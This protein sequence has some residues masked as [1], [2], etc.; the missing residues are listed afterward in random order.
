MTTP[1]NAVIVY[2]G[3]VPSQIAAAPVGEKVVE[4]Y[5][6]NGNLF[7]TSQV[8]Q[9]ESGGGTLLGY[10]DVG[11]AENYRTYFSSLPNSVL[12]PQ[13]PSWPG[14]YQVEYWSS[15]WLSVS[16][17]YIKTMIT[18]GF[19]GCFLD[20][21]TNA[22]TSWAK[23]NAPGGDSEGAMI[24]LIQDVAS[25]AHSINPNFK[26]YAN[27]SGAEDMLSNPSLVKAVDGVFEESL[28][29]QSATQAQ[30]SADV[31][32][33]VALL[34]NVTAAGKPVIDVEY[35][36]N[37]S[38][39]ASVESKDKAYGFGYY[40]ANPDQALNGVDT[41]G[42]TSGATTPGAPTVA[43]T[44]TGGT[45]TSAA[46]TISGTVDVADAGTT[47]KVLEGTTQI[48]S[49]TVGSNGA[50]AAAVTLPT[51]GVNVIAASDSNTTGTGTSNAVTYTLHTVAPTVTITSAGG[52]VTSA[53]QTISGTVDVADASSTVKV[54]DGNAQ[55]GAATVGANGAWSAAVTLPNPGANTISAT[56][57][58][59]AGTG[60][61][62]AVTYT[63]NSASPA[64]PSVKIANSQITVTGGGGTVAMGVSVSAPASSTSTTV[65]IAGLPWYERIT[66]ASDGKTFRGSSITLTQ[67]EVNSGLTL[68]SR[69][70]GAGHPVATLSIT[71][72]DT[73]GGVNYVSPAQ[74]LTV[75]DPPPATSS[76]H[77]D[78]PA[79]AISSLVSGLERPSGFE[80]NQNTG[81]YDGLAC[82][83]SG[84]ATILTNARKTAAFGAG[85]NRNVAEAIPDIAAF[86]LKANGFR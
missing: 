2:S 85:S 6:D 61:S 24:T 59:A 58:N 1:V 39:V 77:P 37:A 62:N 64:A 41:Q 3:I 32:Y 74:T 42:L 45:V 26:I 29:Y 11:E 79:K 67:A 60:T 5:D 73:I 23:S 76:S 48:G 21:I 70:T 44:S 30:S 56:D 19:Q 25:Y 49:A 20:M 66:D 50:W 51:Q 14:S 54:L 55:I 40:I 47:V 4:M 57:V 10:F 78:A 38:E 84:L 7:S 71:A 8:S 72:K 31:N 15:T 33:N 27:I 81:G 52:T 75:V 13:D 16:E 68:Q 46:Q 22:E 83:A 36:S 17:S 9:M 82:A 18:Q 35:I 53:A 80:C 65:T 43:I 63:L 28:F 69:Y 86:D 34:N 12:G